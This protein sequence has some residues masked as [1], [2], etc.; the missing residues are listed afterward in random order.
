MLFNVYTF[1][2]HIFFFSTKKQEMCS[3]CSSCTSSS[4]DESDESVT[5]SSSTDS[6]SDYSLQRQK[7]RAKF[8]YGELC[9]VSL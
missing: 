7:A 8:R 6:S 4:A 2:I 1:P 5:D 3:S 9:D